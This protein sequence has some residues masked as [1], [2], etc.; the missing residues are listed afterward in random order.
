[1]SLTLN[2]SRSFS[3]AASNLSV[4][5]AATL[6]FPCLNFA[7]RFSVNLATSV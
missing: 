6:R 1:M 7:S 2:S 4:K 5:L 3:L